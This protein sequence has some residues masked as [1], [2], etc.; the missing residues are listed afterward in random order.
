[1]ALI[2]LLHNER[3]LTLCHVRTKIDAQRVKWSIENLNSPIDN[4]EYYLVNENLVVYKHHTIGE[5]K[6]FNL[7]RYRP[8]IIKITA[9]PSF[10][11]SCLKSWYDISPKH[12]FNNQ[13]ELDKELIY[14]NPKIMIAENAIAL[15]KC[16]Q[17]I[18]TFTN[19]HVQ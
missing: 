17:I 7:Y 5:I 3:V 18:D 1:M 2:K 9:I 12:K 13:A 15:Q 14:M 11:K 16:T 19:F 10:Y 6:G 4:I 8:R